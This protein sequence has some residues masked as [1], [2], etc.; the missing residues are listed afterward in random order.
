MYFQYCVTLE[1]ELVICAQWRHDGIF[2]KFA[3]GG[4]LYDIMVTQLTANE[5]LEFELE[6]AP[7]AWRSRQNPLGLERERTCREVNARRKCREVNARRKCR[8][9]NARRKCREV[10]AR[11]GYLGRKVSAGS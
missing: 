6:S 8:E 9:V 5:V 2:W 11:Y 1:L 10:N 7:I 3:D 4:K